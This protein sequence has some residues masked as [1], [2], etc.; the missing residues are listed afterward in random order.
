MLA[1][2]ELAGAK[3]QAWQ[4]ARA[5]E[6]VKDARDASMGIQ[7][8][9]DIRLAFE[10]ERTDQLTT[11]R[12]IAILKDDPERPW[13]EY[14][15]GQPITPKQ[16]GAVLRDYGITSETV[17]PLGEPHAKGYKLERFRDAFARYL[18]S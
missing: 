17:H 15:R 3:Q 18:G 6:H 4:A 9:S 16:L 8:L 10:Q 13:A 5:I 11:K 2:A 7:L 1:I 12:L 14:N